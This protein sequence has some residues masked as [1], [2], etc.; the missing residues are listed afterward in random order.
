MTL[1]NVTLWAIAI[2]LIVIV[3]CGC[4]LTRSRK[5]YFVAGPQ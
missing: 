3:P 5:R 2:G 1:M 4:I